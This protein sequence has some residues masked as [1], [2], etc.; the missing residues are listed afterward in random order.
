MPAATRVLA[1]L[2]VFA[3]LF[4]FALAITIISEFSDVE[5]IETVIVI[6]E[7]LGRLTLVSIAIAFILVEGI[8]MLAAWYK[9]EKE[10]QAR[11]EGRA[12]GR[13]EGRAEGRE[14]GRAEGRKEGRAEGL[15]EGRGEAFGEWQDWRVKLEDWERSKAEAEREGREFHEPRP[16]PPDEDQDSA[17]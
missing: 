2:F 15:T 17:V 7:G 10:V 3:A 1:F 11:E 6:G 13:E 4:L 14:E 9:K 8:P 16:L 12:E 5:W